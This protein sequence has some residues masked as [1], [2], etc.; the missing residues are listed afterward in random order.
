[1][2]ARRAEMNSQAP[3][4]RRFIQHDGAAMNRTDTISWVISVCAVSLRLSQAKTLAA[5]VASAVRVERVSLGNIGRKM[6]GTAKHQI[7]RCWRFASNDRVE[8]ADAMRGVVKKILKKRKRPLLVAVDW[9]DI[10]QFQTLMASAVMRGRSVPLCWASCPKHVYDGHRSRNAFEES[11]LLVLVSMIPPGQ[12]V[13]LLADRGFGRTELARFCQRLGLD[14][15]IRI[16]PNVHV[17]CASYSGKLLDYPVHKGICGTGFASSQTAEERGL[18][19]APQRQPEHRRPLGAGSAGQAGRVLVPD[20]QPECRPGPPQQPLRPEDDHRA[21]VPR[22][23]E[24]AQRLEPKGHADH[25]GG[26]SG[27]AAADPGDRLP[28]ALRHRPDRQSHLPARRVVVQ[29][30]E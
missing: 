22:Q 15:V 21:V 26:A 16:Q 30:Q 17:R 24:Q 23:K 4:G 14:Y 8:T 28:A 20:E 13:I 9:V 3:A 7:K 29:Q 5:L 2:A 1:M 6:L 11:L 25:A 12:K 18:P 19:S 27:P 10:R